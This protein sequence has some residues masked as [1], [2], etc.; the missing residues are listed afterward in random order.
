MSDEEIKIVVKQESQGSALA[1]A[2]RDA[3][4]LRKTAG[5]TGQSALASDP[6]E[7]IRRGQAVQAVV[8]TEAAAHAK[9]RE[10]ARITKEAI[11]SSKLEEAALRKGGQHGDA[12]KLAGEIK[13]LEQA[14]QIQRRQNVGYAEAAE[15][16]KSKVE[17]QARENRLKQEGKDLTRQIT[18]EEKEQH[19]FQ[20]ARVRLGGFMASG[21]LLGAQVGFQDYT[22]RQGIRLRDQAQRT[23]DERQIRLNAGARGTSAQALANERGLEDR[24]FERDQNRPE[25]ERKAK[26]SIIN[27]ALIGAGS[28]ALAGGSMGGPWGAAA[29]ALIGAG[30]GAYRGYLEGNRSKQENDTAQARD[31][32]LLETQQEERKR[33]FWAEEGSAELRLLEARSKRTVEGSKQMRI[34]RERMEFMGAYRHFE[35]AGASPEEARRGAELTVFENI[36]DRQQA[37]GASMVNARSSAGDIAAAAAWAGRTTAHQEELAPILHAIF[38]EQRGMNERLSRETWQ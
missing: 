21:A 14:Y 29:G 24:I 13:E 12:D 15:L 7:F 22:E 2:K 34:E 9:I 30:G 6:Q 20:T 31:R 5:G 28:G 23:I 37:I 1:D 18:A 38:K 4:A 32:D 27:Q 16:A 3:E 35:D 26:T 33:K 19:Q 36:K 11:V 25:V 10:E 8:A 17:M